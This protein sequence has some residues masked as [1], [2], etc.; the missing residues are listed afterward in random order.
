MAGGVRT[1]MHVHARTQVAQQQSARGT[2]VAGSRADV[3]HWFWRCTLTLHSVCLFTPARTLQP[4]VR[5]PCSRSHSNSSQNNARLVAAVLVVA[6]VEAKKK[7]ADCRRARACAG[8][9]VCRSRRVRSRLDHALPRTE[10]QAAN[11]RWRAGASPH[12]RIRCGPATWCFSTGSATPRCS[13]RRL[14]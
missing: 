11:L 13:Q 12:S 10:A 8:A 3:L 6:L 5:R 9:A 2:R 4:S 7:A 1:Q 14:V